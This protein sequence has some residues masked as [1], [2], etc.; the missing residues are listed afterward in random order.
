LYTEKW[1]GCRLYTSIPLFLLQ[2]LLKIGYDVFYIF[3]SNAETDQIRLNACLDQFLLIHLAVRMARR[4]ENAAS[5]IRHMGDNGN[6]L[7]FIHHLDGRLSS[8]F[9]AE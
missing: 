8:A 9:Q 7:Q 5:G 1:Y 3:N 2:R 6:Q 4:M